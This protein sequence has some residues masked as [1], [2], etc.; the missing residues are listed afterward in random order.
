MTRN[1]LALAEALTIISNRWRGSGM[2]GE[3]MEAIFILNP[4]QNAV[5]ENESVLSDL[6]STHPPTAKRV[7]IL[8]DMAHAK[9]S[10]LNNALKQAQVRD[11]QADGGATTASTPLPVIPIPIPFPS[12]LP[13]SAIAGTRPSSKDCCPRCQVPLASMTYEGFSVKGCTSCG[14]YLIVEQDVLS[15]VSKREEVFD[16]R[17]QSLARLTREQA[18]PLKNNPFDQIYDEKSIVCPSCFDLQQRMTRRFISAKY[19]V[20]VDKCKICA[21][22]WF[23]KDELE[24]LQ[25][26]YEADQN[27]PSSRG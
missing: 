3:N 1:P 22:V 19:P 8:L 23:D 26:L 17:I 25:C 27:L 5:D 20:E 15:I 16:E 11:I 6:F 12:P 13:V 7:A 18:R 14:G 9:E 2:P 24:I 10:D 4:R 21:R